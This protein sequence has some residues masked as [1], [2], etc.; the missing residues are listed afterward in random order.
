MISGQPKSIRI[1]QFIG[2][3]KWYTR[4][5]LCDD[6]GLMSHLRSPVALGRHARGTPAL[7]GGAK[8]VRQAVSPRRA[9]GPSGVQV[10]RGCSSR[11]NLRGQLRDDFDLR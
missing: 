9:R 11:R 5:W 6:A 10:L 8:G 7:A 2:R 1:L 4:G 3:G